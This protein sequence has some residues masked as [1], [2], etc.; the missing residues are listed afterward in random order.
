MT[1]RLYVGVDPRLHKAA[2]HSVWAHLIHLA[3]QGRV[4]TDGAATLEAVYRSA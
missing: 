1:P 3:R 2:H 4:A